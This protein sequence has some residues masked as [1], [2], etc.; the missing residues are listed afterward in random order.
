MGLCL[1]NVCC[2][3][4]PGI[5]IVLRN[6]CCQKAE[7]G[8]KDQIDLGERPPHNGRVVEVGM[9]YLVAGKKAPL[10]PE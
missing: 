8:D 9:W 10:G 5:S 1:C 6:A 4:L 3:Q 2:E 7:K